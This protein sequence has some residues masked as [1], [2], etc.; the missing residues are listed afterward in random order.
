MTAEPTGAHPPEFVQSLQRG[1]AVIKAFDAERPRMSLSEVAKATGLTPAAARRFLFTLVALGFVDQRD[2]LFELRPAVL[3]LGYAYLSN[4]SLPD[5]AQ[6]HL[7]RFGEQ[8]REA[9][10]LAV[11]DGD[12]V[13][14]V[15]R[16]APPRR[17][18]VTINVGA[19]F[20]A[21]AT[22]LGRVLLAG[23]PDDDIDAYLARVDLRPLTAKTVVEPASLKQELLKVRDQGWSLVDQE[24]EEG[25]LA[26]AVP[27]RWRSDVI[28]AIN[29]S[30]HATEAQA[31]SRRRAL[32]P[33]LLE[34]AA[35]IEADL[36]VYPSLHRFR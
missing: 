33:P 35:R 27:L 23:L 8:S 32:L 20:P 6:P 29:A 25:V 4:L 16:V 34:T 13:R 1:L 26:V 12:D 7:A 22:S 31:E 3:G 9:A 5:V 21:Y 36:A 17:M 15:A 10:S 30:T 24:L 14:Y 2:G 18:A 19:R 11:L 28:G